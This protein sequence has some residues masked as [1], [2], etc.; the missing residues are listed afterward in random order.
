MDR[1]DLALPFGQNEL[2]K[3]VVAA[4]PRTIVVIVAGAPVEMQ[5]VDSIAPAI[6]Y[7]WF[8]GS[9]GG[10]A[11]ADVL[12]GDVNPSGKLP[13]TFPA[14]LNDSPAHAMNAYPG[15]STVSYSE[16]ILVGYRWFDTKNI[17]P[18]YCFGYG[19]SYTEFNYSGLTTDKPEYRSGDKIK[20][21]LNLKNTGN[22]EGFEVVQLYVSDMEPK[23]M[24]AAKE[25][26]AFK[27]IPV[28]IGAETF[29]NLELNASDLSYFDESQMKWVLSPGKYKIRV[30]SSSQ[31]MRAETVITIK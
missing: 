13:F 15:D 27:K 16:G 29:V 22:R 3:A 30:G 1:P 19:L 24:K 14:K 11:L 21:A 25:L 2:I 10:T 18:T 8:N 6:L 31:D 9:E 7:S 23:V 5:T 4:N 17:K 12:F 20:V 26:K 28:A